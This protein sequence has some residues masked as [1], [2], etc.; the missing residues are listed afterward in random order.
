MDSKGW[1][2]RGYLP[3]FDSPEM[4][5]FVTFRLADSPPKAVAQ[6]L[7]ALPDNL[8]QTDRKLDTG[9][10]A[11][12]LARPDIA[13]IVESALLHFDGVRY[14]LL[15]WCIMPNHVHVIV[16]PGTDNPL[17]RIVHSWKSY[18]AQ[19][20]NR[21]LV[22]NDPFWHRDYFDRF[23]RDE[24]HLNRTIHYVENNPVK[25]G[26]ISEAIEW[27]WGSARRRA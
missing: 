12:W 2:S 3:H 11:C 27:P 14:R 7:A 6:A 15:A 1:Y 22:R 18:S 23:M 8:L 20:A 26:L 21:L 4:V 17:D 25:A 24:D 13:G 16:E 19:R 9:L 5:Q 10:G